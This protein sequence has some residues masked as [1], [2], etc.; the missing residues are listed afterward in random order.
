[1]TEDLFLRFIHPAPPEGP[2]CINPVELKE[3]KTLAADHTLLLLLYRRL[4]DL[5][6]HIVP[7]EVVLSFIKETK[8]LYYKNV[9]RTTRQ[10]EIAAKIVSLFEGQG[11]PSLVFRGSK[12]AADIYG[13]PFCRTSADIDILVRIA[14]VLTTDEI[15]TKAGF[16]R[17]DGLPLKF[18]LSRLHHA[19]YRTADTSDLIE[20]HWNFSIPSY[21]GLESE[22][23]WDGIASPK[24]EE[25][26]LSPE[27]TLIQLLMHHH[28]HAFRELKI[29]VDI[30]WVLHRYEKS[31]DW[32][33]FVTTIEKTGL[34]KIALVALSQIRN[35]WNA[36][37]SLKTGEMLSVELGRRRY[38]A[39]AYLLSF[40]SLDIKKRYPFQSPGDKFMARLALDCWST[41]L[42][43]F[44]KT[45]FP[46]PG[47][48]KVLYEDYRNWTLPVH[49][50]R[51]IAW[52]MK[53][54]NA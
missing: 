19:V 3:I 44:T 8:A 31:I 53:N 38:R 52:R 36:T 34:S 54:W 14:D 5:R 48:I 21:F 26:R 1:M 47:A 11:I 46:P 16:H 40:F 42:Q 24:G 7:K 9:A 37:D 25:P 29:L 6:E 45:F 33:Q 22:E 27:M 12:I 49:Y 20:I 2:V 15:M 39:P 32:Q 4:S 23:I 51:F 28:M 30:L 43:S 41:I 50:L 17:T 18:L 10:Q 13:D 35:L